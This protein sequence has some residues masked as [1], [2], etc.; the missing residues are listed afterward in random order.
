MKWQHKIVDIDLSTGYGRSEADALLDALG[1]EG[2]E[3]V[4]VITP[5]DDESLRWCK[6]LLKRPT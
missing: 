6:C 1:E 4:T 5:T 3:A 2:W